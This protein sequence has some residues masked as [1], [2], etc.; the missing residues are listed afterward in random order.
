MELDGSSGETANTEVTLPGATA[1]TTAA[2]PIYAPPG[3]MLFLPS[4]ETPHE[5][6]PA[7]VQEAPRRGC[8]GIVVNVRPGESDL[9][10]ELRKYR[11]RGH[12]H[13]FEGGV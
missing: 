4:V 6:V 2:P 13:Y 5:A 11:F 9:E 1:I 7:A 3:P 12:C 8:A 10:A